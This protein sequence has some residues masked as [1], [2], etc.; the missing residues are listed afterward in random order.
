MDSIEIEY[1]AKLAVLEKQFDA[2]Y[3]DVGVHFGLPDCMMWILYFLISSSEEITQQD[4]IEKMMFPKQTINSAVKALLHK[5]LVTLMMI[6]HTK[7]R[8]K[9]LL[10]EAG[11]DLAANTVEKMRVAEMGAVRN[12]G[13]KRMKQFVKLFSEFFASMK[14]EFI[15]DGLVYDK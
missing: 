2:L 15:K 13:E 3:R 8:K 6:P 9:I 4:L 12:M 1:L 14:N 7:N 5:G 10:T 11:K